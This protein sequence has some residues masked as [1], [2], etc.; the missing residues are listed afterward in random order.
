MDMRSKVLFFVFLLVT[1]E[2]FFS[3]QARPLKVHEDDDLLNAIDHM[4][5]VELLEGIKIEGQNR[6]QG[7]AFVKYHL[8]GVKNSG[9]SPGDGH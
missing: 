4:I 8:D 2:F 9:P 7:C 1:S 3:A 6:S 5:G